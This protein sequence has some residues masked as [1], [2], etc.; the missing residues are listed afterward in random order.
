MASDA[1]PD[2][3]L[4]DVSHEDL[5]DLA[6]D[7]LGS[8]GVESEEEVN[9][10]G[11]GAINQ[12]EVDA[13]LAENGF[14]TISFTN[15]YTHERIR[16]HALISPLGSERAK[17]ASTSRMTFSWLNMQARQL[18]QLLCDHQ[19]EMRARML[20]TAN[21][22]GF[23]L[24]YAP[25]LIHLAQDGINEL[26]FNYKQMRSYRHGEE[27]YLYAKAPASILIPTLTEASH[28]SSEGD[29]DKEA[30]KEDANNSTIIR[31]AN[32][33]NGRLE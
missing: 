21:E 33:S 26:P 17:Y 22:S 27:I 8:H 30:S 2:S 13:T 12:H 10:P 15:R 5:L 11:K 19:K 16:K 3:P 1:V 18:C 6:F 14:S 4:T 9:D 20:G 24:G 25:Y 23:S 29:S 32:S 7:A 31:S 28:S